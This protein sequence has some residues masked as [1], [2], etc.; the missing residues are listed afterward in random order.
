[1]R[2]QAHTLEGTT[3]ALLVLTSI[4]FA[5]QMTAVTPI[6]ASTTNQHIENQQQAAA[7]GV[8]ST[9]AAED[10]ISAALRRWNETEGTFVGAN[11]D[12]H[13]V[14]GRTTSEFGELLQET[15]ATESVAYTVAFVYLT[16]SGEDRS[17]PH[18]FVSSGDPSDSA[19]TVTRTVT[20]FDAETLLDASGNATA[21]DVEGSGLFRGHDLPGPIYNVVEVRVIVWRV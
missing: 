13:Y 11:T 5:L 2:G 4:L 10:A 14:A 8:L 12:G 19:V 20:V 18:V 6:T 3:T 15:F 7:R 21:G 1:M 16:E 17:D 9:A